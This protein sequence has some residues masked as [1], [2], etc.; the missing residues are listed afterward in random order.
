[1]FVSK[2]RFNELLE[3]VDLLESR[4]N[5]VESANN[6]LKSIIKAQGVKINELSKRTI[7]Q[8][9]LAKDA[10]PSV[11]DIID[12]WLNGEEEKNGD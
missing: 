3:R 6:K 11:N 4:C 8:T 2:K 5:S 7:S 1:M 9:T 10:P 12:E